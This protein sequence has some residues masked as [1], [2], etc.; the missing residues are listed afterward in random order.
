MTAREWECR[1]GNREMAPL[2][3]VCPGCGV[4]GNR[5]LLDTEITLDAPVTPTSLDDASYHFAGV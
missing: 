4:A 5:R 2:E 1:C 3:R